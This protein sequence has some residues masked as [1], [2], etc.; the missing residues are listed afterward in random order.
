[1]T[2]PTFTVE[3]GTAP[4]VDPAAWVDVTSRV[5][6]SQVSFG[7]GRS[8][9]LSD[10]TAGTGSLAL[11]NLDGN[12]DPGI[13]PDTA[14][15]ITATHNALTY[16]VCYQLVQSAAASWPYAGREAVVPVDLADG[17]SLLALA[18]VGETTR[19]AELTG[20]RI[21]AIL[22]LA[23]WPADMR[24]LDTGRVY[25]DE[26]GDYDSDGNLQ[27]VIVN[28]LAAIRDAVEV[29]QG[30]VYIAPD[31]TFV[32]HDRLSRIDLALGQNYGGGYLNGYESGGGSGSAVTFGSTLRYQDLVPRYDAAFLWPT[33][34]AEMADGSIIEHSDQD[35]LD[36]GYGGLATG[37]P[38][39]VYVVRD[40]ATSDIEADVLAAWIVVRYATPRR[41]I[42]RL[43]LTATDEDD[44]TLVVLFGL[45][46]GQVVRVQSEAVGTGAAVDTYQHIERI[47]HNIGRTTWAA[48]LTL[49][50]YFGEGPWLRLDDPVKGV[51]D[52]TRSLAP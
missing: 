25:I 46:P 18:E 52:G 44:D 48:T 16:P 43:T 19:P 33:A 4:G 35:A 2:W 40:L 30:Q 28:A 26:L 24:D 27:D 10:N 41:R 42:E 51:L 17:M 31:G 1:M 20:T 47:D 38:G 8:D 37:Q 45:R 34:R 14:L 50:P 3:L 9:E 6:G 21:G 39:R 49:S 12:W 13:D 32:F 15:R 7:F 22:D 11:D 23:G 36:A 29:E 5:L